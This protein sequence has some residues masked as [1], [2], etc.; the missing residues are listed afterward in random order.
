VSKHANVFT[1][2]GNNSQDAEPDADAVGRTEG[3]EDAAPYSSFHLR[4]GEPW[5]DTMVT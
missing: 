1:S 2:Y 3:M 4:S 5:V